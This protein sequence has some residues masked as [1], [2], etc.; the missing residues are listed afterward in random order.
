VQARTIDAD[1]PPPPS[2][3]ERAR[4][5][6]ALESQTRQQVAELTRLEKE[7]QQRS[8]LAVKQ[9]E[10][11]T[12]L[13]I[14]L[15]NTWSNVLSTNWTV[16]QELRR[17]AAGCTEK[18]APCTICDGQGTMHFCVVCDN[19]GQCIDCNGKGTTPYG[20]RCPTCRGKGKCYLCGGSGKMPCLFCDDGLVYSQGVPPPLYLPLPGMP[21]PSTHPPQGNPAP[22]H[23]HEH[24]VAPAG[25]APEV[26]ETQRSETAQPAPAPAAKA[27]TRGTMLGLAALLLL[28]GVVVL[29]KVIPAI[30]GFFNGRANHAESLAASAPARSGISFDEQRF[31]EFAATFKTG[32]N[33]LAKSPVG[34]T[35]D[36][37]NDLRQFFQIAP[38]RLR[39]IKGFFSQ[40]SHA[41]D[42]ETRQ[43]ILIELSRQF[44]SFRLICDTPKLREVYQ[45]ATALEG[46]IKQMADRPSNI[47]PSALR[48]AASAILLLETLSHPGVSLIPPARPQLHFLAVDDDIIS[49]KAVSL[50]LKKTFSEPDLAENAEAA[51]ALV[52]KETYD[53]IFLDVEMPGMDGFELCA[54]IRQSELNASTPVVFVTS[55]RDFD[56]RVKSTQSGGQDLIGKPFLVFEITVKALTLVLRSRFPK[57]FTPRPVI[58]LRPPLETAPDGRK[59]NGITKHLSTELN[60]V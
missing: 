26:N 37:S 55:H 47:T 41:A 45:L 21:V 56:S 36:E 59:V 40:F 4:E 27:D 1:A 29:R 54:R 30:T 43:N 52:A 8:E 9:R 38:E 14:T 13:Q 60:A 3:Q 58:H 57:N 32:L 24:I 20:E 11:L 48:T 2:E 34:E 7:R 46:L 25:S 42:E 23:E 39:P 49:R 33:V 28:A 53:V 17:K 6:A 50:S 51:L 10:R 18:T 31:A 35:R 22:I 15:A 44:R 5:R 12:R 19:H 16:Y